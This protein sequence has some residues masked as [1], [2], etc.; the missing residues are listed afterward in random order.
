M[1]AIDDEG[2]PEEEP[3]VGDEELPGDDEEEAEPPPDDDSAVP[4]DP[5]AESP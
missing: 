2:A 4:V 3:D 1:T 5:D